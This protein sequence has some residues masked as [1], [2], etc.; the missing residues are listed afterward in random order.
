MSAYP[1]RPRDGAADDDLLVVTFDEDFGE[2][3]DRKAVRLL[4]ELHQA[5]VDGHV[6]RDPTRVVLVATFAEL[7]RLAA[8]PPPESVDA[9]RATGCVVAEP[10]RLM[11]WLRARLPGFAPAVAER[12]R[13]RRARQAVLV[14]L[15]W[16]IEFCCRVDARGAVLSRGGTA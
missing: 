9:E 8:I 4:L 6:R 11:P 16:G 5:A 12:I 7:A 3:P 1:F 14:V 10:S 15:A 13:R 2:G